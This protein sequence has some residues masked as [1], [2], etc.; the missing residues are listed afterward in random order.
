MP[1][2]GSGVVH[3]RFVASIEAVAG[4][5]R[6]ETAQLQE[7]QRVNGPSGQTTTWVDVGDPVDVRVAP[8]STLRGHE[9]LVADQVQGSKL[10]VLAGPA[11]WPVEQE[12]RVV[13]NGTRTFEVGEILGPHSYQP[14]LRVVAEEVGL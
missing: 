11:D 6:P 3:P 10:V 5:T 1:R 9:R 4:T 7:P 14:E 13:V 12:H 8:I 2:P